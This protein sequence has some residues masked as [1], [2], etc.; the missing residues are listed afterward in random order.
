VQAAARSAAAP[1]PAPAEPPHGQ[2]VSARRILPPVL[3][4]RRRKAEHLW[5]DCWRVTLPGDGR[6]LAVRGTV[7]KLITILPKDWQPPQTA[8]NAAALTEENMPIG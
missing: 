5:E 3:A 7:W 1:K 4:D 2:E 8:V 6:T